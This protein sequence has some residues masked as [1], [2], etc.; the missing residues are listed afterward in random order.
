MNMNKTLLAIVGIAVVLGGWWLVQKNVAVP[1]TGDEVST[2][3]VVPTSPSVSTQGEQA[4][5]QPLTVTISG[6]EFKYEPALISAKVGQTVTVT[7]TNTGKYPH[8]FVID[9]LSVKSQVIKAGETEMFSFVPSK[10]G[11][12][13]FYCSLPNHREKG[14]SG[15]LNVE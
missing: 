2:E 15:V 10:T 12:F 5:V 3:S 11:T 14:M 9:E 13:A 8:D 7:Y 1:A 4:E 6:N